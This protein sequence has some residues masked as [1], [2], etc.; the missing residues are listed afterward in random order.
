MD[1]WTERKTFVKRQVFFVLLSA[2]LFIHSKANKRLVFFG[3]SAWCVI[4]TRAGKDDGEPKKIKKTHSQ[5]AKSFL[6]PLS[7]SPRIHQQHQSKANKKLYWWDVLG[8]CAIESRRRKGAMKSTR[9]AKKGEKIRSQN[10]KSFLFLFPHRH[11]SAKTS[12]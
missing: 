9:A 12:I 8:W 7:A 3:L 5:N 11:V 4:E 2:S 10:A 6:L 1:D